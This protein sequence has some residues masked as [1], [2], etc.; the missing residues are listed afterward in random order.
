MH[1]SLQDTYTQQPTHYKIKTKTQGSPKTRRH[2]GHH[3][4]KT[5][6]EDRERRVSAYAI[7]LNI[8]RFIYN[9]EHFLA[10]MLV[11]PILK[12][13]FHETNHKMKLGL[14]NNAF[15]ISI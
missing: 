14:R 2:I 1:G 5:R 9:L 11:P 12:T 4:D 6:N 7:I 3:T 8:N 10:A 13:P 15:T